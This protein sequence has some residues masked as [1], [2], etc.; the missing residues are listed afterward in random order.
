MGMQWLANATG[1]SSEWFNLTDLHPGYR[2]VRPWGRK[3][4]LANLILRS[5]G[6]KC[7]FHL[8]KFEVETTKMPLNLKRHQYSS[9]TFMQEPL[10]SSKVW[11]DHGFS[12]PVAPTWTFLLI[13]SWK[14]SR[15]LWL[16]MF[17]SNSLLFTQNHLFPVWSKLWPPVFTGP[18][19]VRV[20]KHG[21]FWASESLPRPHQNSDTI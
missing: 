8:S 3:L 2:S 19:T 18:S 20:S 6:P 4:C 11:E 9:Q 17:Y 13:Q 14:C 21:P 15:Y 16:K 7:R 12:D 5:L 1:T 10:T